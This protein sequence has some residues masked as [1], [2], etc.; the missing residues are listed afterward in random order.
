[1]TER[2]TVTVSLVGLGELV[3]RRRRATLLLAQDIPVHFMDLLENVDRVILVSSKTGYIQW[4]LRDE[5]VARDVRRLI[6]RGLMV[7][8]SDLPGVYKVVLT[9]RGLEVVTEVKRLREVRK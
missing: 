7:V 9:E 4:A 3:G 5:V 2:E 6:A 8:R 1:M